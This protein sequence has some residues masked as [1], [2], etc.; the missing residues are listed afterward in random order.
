MKQQLEA[1]FGAVS[2]DTGE[3][4][5]DMTENPA[6]TPAHVVTATKPEQV[7]DLLKLCNDQGVPVTPKVTGQNVAGLAIPAEGGV[8]LDLSALKGIEIDR[9]NMVAWIEP[10]VSWADLKEAAEAQELVLGFPLAPPDSS[11]LACA[12]MDGLSTM[13]LAHG[14][15]GDWVHGVVAYLAD[16]TRVVTGSAAVSGR[17]LSR[18]PLPDLTGMFINWFGASGVVVRMG[19]ALWP[20]R[21][22]RFREVVPCHDAETAIAFMRAAARTGLFDD[23]GGIGWPAAKWALGLDRLDERDPNEPE[24]YLIADYRADT[25]AEIAVKA[26][27]L[28]ELA[29]TAPVRVDDLQKLVPELAPFAELPVRLGFL[30]DHEGGGLTWV[31]TYGPLENIAE[32]IRVGGKLLSDAG[33]PPLSVTRPMKGGHYGVLRFIER[34]DRSSEEETRK[35]AELNV[36]LAEALMDLGFVPYKCPGVLYDALYKRLDP[37]FAEMMRRLRAAID[38]NGILNPDRWS[39]LCAP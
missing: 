39:G 1:I 2:A 37:G 6:R 13:A 21:K 4:A 34:F 7:A 26:R 5:A 23:V 14:S 25:E 20:K 10:G 15:Y 31:G 30:M 18:G 16:G 22:Y 17:P 9:D 3:H 38:P 32:G 28:R 12:L 29:P 35:I 36:A 24:L 11:V 8:V 19:L 27:R 33:H